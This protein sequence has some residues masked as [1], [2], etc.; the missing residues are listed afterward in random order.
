M[1]PPETL[2]SKAAKFRAGL[3]CQPKSA[4][5]DSSEEGRNGRR[6]KKS[7]EGVIWLLVQIQS[8]E[9]WHDLPGLLWILCWQLDALLS[10]GIDD[11]Q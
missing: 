8:L 4:K 6:P 7:W 5:P 3:L 9:T 2:S 10:L 11:H 1:G